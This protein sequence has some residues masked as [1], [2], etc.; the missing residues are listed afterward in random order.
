MFARRSVLSAV[1]LAAVFVPV[2]LAQAPEPPAWNWMLAAQNF[3]GDEN[4][5]KELKLNAE[6]VKTANSLAGTYRERMI[7]RLSDQKKRES[8]D[9]A[10]KKDHEGF[11]KA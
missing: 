8:I 9:K 7:E 11:L 4:L 1:A 3:L 10:I 2:A 5:Q 6:Q